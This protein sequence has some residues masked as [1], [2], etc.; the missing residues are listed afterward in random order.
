MLAAATPGTSAVTDAGTWRPIPPQYYG[1]NAVYD[2]PRDR[3]LVTGGQ[4]NVFALSLPGTPAWTQL[5][6]VGATPSISSSI[7]DPVRDRVIVFGG[8]GGVETWTLPL[9]GTP[10]WT[11]M[12]TTGSPPSSASAAIYDSARD[13]A[14]VFYHTQAFALSLTSNTWTQIAP[15]GATPSDRFGFAAIYDPLRDRVVIFSGDNNDYP[16]PN[17]VWALSLAGTPAWMELTPAGMAPPGRSGH[18]GIYDPVR[19]RMLI[20]DGYNSDVFALDDTWALSFSGTPTWTQLSPAGTTPEARALH[21]S[22]YDPVRDRM[23]IYGGEN[24]RLRDDAL[25]DTHALDLASGTWEPV[26]VP[27]TQRSHHS[28]IYDAPHDRMIVFGGFGKHHFVDDGALLPVLTLGSERWSSLATTGGPGPA[29]GEAVYDAVGN[30]MVVIDA[31]DGRVWALSLSATPA[32]SD[33]T[34]AGVPPLDGPAVYD[35][36]RDRVLV[37]SDRAWALSLAGVPVWAEIKPKDDSPLPRTGDAIMYDPVRD[38]LLMFGGYDGT[39]RNDVMALSLTGA[40]EWSTLTPAGASPAPRRSATTIY[41][42][43]RDRMVMYGGWEDR[44]DVW[45]FSLGAT[46]AWTMLMPDGPKPAGRSSHTAIYDALRDRMVVFGG[47]NYYSDF[48]DAWVLE[49][50]ATTDDTPPTITV[51]LD[52]HTLWP[53]NHKMI[54]VCATV[55][56]SDNQDPAPTFRLVDIAVFDGARA[57]SAADDVHGATLGTAD[58]CFE[59]RATRPGNSGGREYRIVY[60]A[61]DMSDNATLD[62][63]SV[64]V[65]ANASSQALAGAEPAVTALSSVYPNP[66]NPQTTVDYS[67]DGGQRVVIAVYDV[68]GSLVRTLVDGTEAAGEH[69]VTWNGADGAGVAASSGIYFLRMTAGAYSETRKIVMLK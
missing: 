15:A 65:P 20:F 47:E 9:T 54:P 66:F 13:R 64:R 36:A 41:D 44:A 14:L 26:L 24:W 51:E 37:I 62:T 33:I 49:W 40:P 17:D 35:P 46:P 27:P 18:T 2:P 28:A 8:A 39:L 23:L 30:R 56:V 69:H 6:V 53:P 22:I 34:P 3:M 48:N 5:T 59:L 16:D 29:G 19:D 58:L 60:E 7:Y 67:L 57:V 21:C 45:A 4:G 31:A 55:K 38:R 43:V 42:P 63:V 10:A 1:A 12:A 52:H 68:R 32:W 11:Q 50:G 25:F 61:R